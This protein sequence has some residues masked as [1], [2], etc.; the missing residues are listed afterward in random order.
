MRFLS[1]KKT[2][3]KRVRG[4]TVSS[5]QTRRTAPGKRTKPPGAKTKPAAGRRSAAG[6]PPGRPRKVAARRPPGRLSR[7]QVAGLGLC[8]IALSVASGTAWLWHDGWFSRQAELAVERAYAL[9]ASAGLRVDDLQVVGRHRTEARAILETMDVRRGM[10]I[11]RLDTDATRRKLEA[12]PWVK[13]AEVSR[14]LPNVVAVRLVERQP[15]AIW[16][17]QGA[18]S[19]IDQD[20]EVIPDVDVRRFAELPVVV[21]EDAP[22]EAPRLLAMLGSEPALKERV[23]AAVWVGGRR[24]NLQLDGGID[25]RLPEADPAAAWTQLAAVE[26]EHGLLARDVITIDLRLPD[27]LV[28]QTAPGTEG[29]EASHDTGE[30]T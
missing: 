23:T 15:L 25:V 14:H 27:R 5:E 22:E 24:W 10:A 16:Q 6:R 4:L 17:L 2:S 20:G 9:S 18:L 21:G 3:D 13:Q 19:L 30:N 12:L 26:R 28:V 8:L 11:L 1:S 7:R 29:T